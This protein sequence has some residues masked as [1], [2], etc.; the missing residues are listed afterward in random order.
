MKDY[1]NKLDRECYKAK[2]SGKNGATLNLAA[3]RRNRKR[4]ARA[5]LDAIIRKDVTNG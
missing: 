5:K 4:G 1:S 3:V 2:G